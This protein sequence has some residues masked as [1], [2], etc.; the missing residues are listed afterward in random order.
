MSL[1]SRHSMSRDL[2]SLL[3]E[4]PGLSQIVVPGRVLPWRPVGGLRSVHRAV[5]L[6]EPLP[7]FS[8]HAVTSGSGAGPL[9]RSLTFF[10]EAPSRNVS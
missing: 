1:I 5:S 2:L 8:F 3:S 7:C 9:C 4:S 10:Q 6:V